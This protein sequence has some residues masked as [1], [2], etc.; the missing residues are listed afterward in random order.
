MEVGVANRPRQEA[1][2]PVWGQ[3]CLSHSEVGAVSVN[4]E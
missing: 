2:H 1:P 3:A 4:F